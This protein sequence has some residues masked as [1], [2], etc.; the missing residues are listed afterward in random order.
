MPDNFSDLPLNSGHFAFIASMRTTSTVRHAQHKR[1]LGEFR[2]G[3]RHLSVI[4]AQRSQSPQAISPGGILRVKHSKRCC[5]WKDL[6]NWSRKAIFQALHQANAPLPGLPCYI[7]Q[8]GSSTGAQVRAA[9]LLGLSEHPIPGFR[10]ALS[11]HLGTFS[12]CRK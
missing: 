3:G 11:R 4:L 5:A 8:Q 12:P 1:L 2:P 7:C 6:R 9:F 10:R